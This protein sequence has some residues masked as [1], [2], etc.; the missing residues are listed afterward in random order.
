MTAAI[1]LSNIGL[2]LDAIGAIFFIADTNRLFLMLTG[3]VKQI[4][5]DNGKFDAHVFSPKEIQSL[6]SG[7]KSSRRFNLLGALFLGVGFLLQIVSN[8]VSGLILLLERPIRVDDIV[9]VGD[10]S[11]T[12]KSITIR[13]TVIQN[14]DNQTVIIPNKEFIAH[15]VT[16]WTLGNTYVR[17]VLPVGVAYGSDLD[18]VK[19]LLTET[20]SSHPRVLTT[21]PPAVFLLAFG[22]HALQWEI[23]CFV[24]RPQDRPATAHDLLLQIEQTFRQHGIAIP[25][26]Q[27]DIH[28]RSAD[29]ALVIQ[30]VG[31]G[32]S[33]VAAHAE[34]P[35]HGAP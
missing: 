1:W 34:P 13:A 12:V 15:R 22:E 6:Q 9:T 11:G 33:G 30:P 10:Q 28:L 4:A 2:F 32:Y 18:L 16:N 19:R 3:I 23:S 31:N 8:F 35:A 29:A 27:Q 5:E 24:P 21:P 20:V 17:L 25:F 26:P 7:I 14:A